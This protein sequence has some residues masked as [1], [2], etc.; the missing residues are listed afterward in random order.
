MSNEITVPQSQVPA[1]SDELSLK[2]RARIYAASPMV[3]AAF[4]NKPHEIFIIMEMAQRSGVDAMM[5]LQNSYVVPNTG[6]PGIETKLAI[7]LLM[8]SRATLGPITY[9]LA[10][11]GD[12]LSC[13]ASVTVRETGQVVT[14]R[15]HWETVVSN[16][17]HNN[18]GWKKDRELMMCYRAASRLIR[19]HFPDVLLGCITREEAQ[20]MQTINSTAKQVRPAGKLQE[21]ALP[22]PPTLLPAAPPAP[23]TVEHG[24]AWEPDA[25]ELDQIRKQ[26]EA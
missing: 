25:E 7:T 14:H 12:Q 1:V 5:W 22:A 4:R 16:G 15:L 10:G 11:S 13:T 23:E 17:W 21:R 9:A 18:P 6:K 20:D 24:D 19:L 3:P 8:A 26:E 2:D